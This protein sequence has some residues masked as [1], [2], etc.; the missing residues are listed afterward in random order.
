MLVDK[1]YR[2]RGLAKKMLK[3]SL[4]NI[5]KKYAGDGNAVDGNGDSVLRRKNTDK[6]DVF[7]W[8]TVYNKAAI[9]LYQTNSFQEIFRMRNIIFP[10]IPFDLIAMRRTIDKEYLSLQ[11]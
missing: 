3:I 10:E 11:K 8:S 6:I 1:N 2:R 5:V 9:N 7:L 4:D